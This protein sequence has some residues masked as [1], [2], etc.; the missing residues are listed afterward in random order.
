MAKL[1][2]KSHPDLLVGMESPDDAG[3]YR[4]NEDTALIQSL[5]FFTP[6]VDSPYEFGLIAAANA[7]SDIY[8]MGGR[9]VTA[10]NIVCFPADDLSESVLK[11]TLEG[12]LEKIHE[13]GAVLVGGHSVDDT[14]FKYG[15][16]VTGLIHPEKILT[17][18]GAVTGDRLI[19]T[20]PVGLGVLATA[21]KGGM[22][23]AAALE[24]MVNTAA[25]LN[26]KAAE[27]AIRFSATACTDIT[28]FGLAGHILEMARGGK[29]QIR[30]D[31]GSVPVI[32]QALEYGAMGLFPA[33][34]Y[35]NKKH[36]SDSIHID[37]SVADITAD[38]MFDP[39][40]SGGLAVAVT[41]GQA[42]HCLSAMRDAG[43]E[44]EII[45]EIGAQD[46]CGQVFI[47]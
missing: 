21:V 36:F 12:G 24:K 29:K 16:S 13:A 26:R 38:L 3:V 41:P 15:L 2:V 5:D 6:M 40:T 14:E 25:Q 27:I 33:G 18:G 45:G 10:M 4:I 37:E 20:K 1:P 44:A 31:A 43:L 30:L 46:S 47:H 11:E 39:Q 8:A 28:G 23:D 35:T 19:L 7:F 9:P 17:N 22:A 34:A 32:A 42:E